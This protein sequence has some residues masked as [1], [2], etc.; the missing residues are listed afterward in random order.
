M[1][2]RKA[3][4]VIP[5]DYEPDTTTPVEYVKHQLKV[6]APDGTEDTIEDRIQKLREDAPP[7]EILQFLSTFQRVR[8]TMGWTTGPKL[9]QK[10]PMHLFGYQHLD[11]WEL[12]RNNQNATVNNFELTQRVPY[13]SH[14]LPP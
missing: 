1:A 5:F 9:F 12:L 7:F 2:H 11:L 4:P 10:F 13:A 6:R 3:M 14:W 8:Q